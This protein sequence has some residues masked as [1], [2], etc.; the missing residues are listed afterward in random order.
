VSNGSCFRRPE[1]IILPASGETESGFAGTQPDKGYPGSSAPMAREAPEADVEWKPSGPNG[2]A[3]KIG[4]SP[5]YIMLK[6]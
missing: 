6:K 2:V 1:M 4:E 3:L 5:V